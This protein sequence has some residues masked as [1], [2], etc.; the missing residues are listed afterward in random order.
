MFNDLFLEVLNHEGAVTIVTLGEEKTAVTN[1][2]NSYVTVKDDK[3][4]IPAA[5]MHSVEEVIK[6]DNQLKL[7][8]AS[9][10]VTGPTGYQG[11]GFHVTGK[12]Y[13]LEEGPEFEEKK[14]DYPWI[15]RV[16]VIEA[17]KVEQKI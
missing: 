15:T 8:I 4:Y 12:G 9:K 16:L 17:E 3:L 5:G 11:A 1:T 2:W 10:E 6:N 7:A 13:F 14:K